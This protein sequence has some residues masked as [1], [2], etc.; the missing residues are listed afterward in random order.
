MHFFI[1]FR[2][3]SLASTQKRMDTNQADDTD[4]ANLSLSSYLSFLF[5]PLSFSLALSVCTRVVLCMAWKGSSTRHNNKKVSFKKNVK[6]VPILII[7]VL[8]VLAR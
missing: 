6:L 1:L 7:N 4:C 2:T 5:S 3:R 8:T